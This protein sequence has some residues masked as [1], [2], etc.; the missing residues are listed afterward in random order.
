MAV[1]DSRSVHERGPEWLSESVLGLGYALAV[2]AVL[3]GGATVILR[4]VAAPASTG[5]TPGV[6]ETTVG[7]VL[8]YGLLVVLYG[9][10]GVGAT[11]AYIAYRALDPG[12]VVERPDRAALR[13]LAGL[14]VLAVGLVGGVGLAVSPRGGPLTLPG[15]FVAPAWTATAVRGVPFTVFGPVSVLV[16]AGVVGPAVGT[17]FHGVVQNSLRRVVPASVAATGTA[18][19]L[20]VAAGTS[21]DPLGAV[22]VAGFAAAT[23][24]AYERTGNLAVPMVAYAALNAVTLTTA[25]VFVLQAGRL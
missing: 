15:A 4:A 7:F 21:A 18:L 11:Y 3:V 22:V 8:A 24:Y 19:V 2:T 12:F 17:L 25:V 13:W 14:L 10:G 23:G 5:S 16:V 20:A 6:F 9:V 1:N